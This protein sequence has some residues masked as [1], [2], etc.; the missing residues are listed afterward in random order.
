MSETETSGSPESN[1]V[2]ENTEGKTKIVLEE[3]AATLFYC[4][5]PEMFGGNFPWLCISVAGGEGD[6]LKSEPQTVFD[7]VDW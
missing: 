1:D 4:E 7:I 2:C 3:N 5:A 6:R